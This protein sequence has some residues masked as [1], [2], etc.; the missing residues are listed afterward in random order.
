MFWSKP[1]TISFADSQR[2][3]VA[4][5]RD[6]RCNYW[7]ERIAAVSTNSFQS[8]LGGMGS[9]SDLI[10]CRENHHEITPEKEPLAN[11]LVGCLA[12]ICYATSKTGSATL[13]AAVASCGTI[14]LVLSGWRCLACGHA[15]I[16]PRSVRAVLAAVNV[17]RA[18]GNGIARRSPYEEIVNLWQAKED[19]D[20]LRVLIQ[21][22]GESGIAYSQADGW[23]R[24]C[25]HCG[26][27]D[28][29]VY[30]WQ[31][32]R[33]KFIPASDNLPLRSERQTSRNP[34]S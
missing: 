30:R 16:S 24:P 34:Q 11:E 1:K 23:M 7:A 3:L 28:T 5:L 21:K 10:I 8:L 14:S 17:R 29:C 18:I 27:N 26:G 13:D 2:A 25:P 9:L 32:D 19:S 4:I 12:S 31:T 15:Q 22:A 33:D 20:S 6:V